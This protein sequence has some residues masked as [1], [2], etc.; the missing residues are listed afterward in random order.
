MA[1]RVD[2]LEI[3]VTRLEELPARMDRLEGQIVSLRTEMRA[4]FSAVRSEMAAQTEALRVSLTKHTDD[5]M[6]GLRTHMRL[7]HEEVLNRISLTSEGRRA[8][9]KR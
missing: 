6:A 4:E 7:L 8:R 2:S 9:R 1:E 3:R 5:S